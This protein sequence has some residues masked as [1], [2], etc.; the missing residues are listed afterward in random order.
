MKVLLVNPPFHEGYGTFSESAG[1][2][3]PLGLAYIAAM[4]EKAGIFVEIID[5]NALFMT[6][7]QLSM[8]IFE[9]H[10]DIV[11]SSVMTSTVPIVQKLARIAKQA[12]PNSIFIGGGVH[13]TACPIETLERVPEIDIGVIGEGEET[14]VELVKALQLKE[15]LSSVKG[16]AFRETGKIIVTQ[17]R[18]PIHNLDELPFPAYHLLPV[19]KYKPRIY[20]NIKHKKIVYMPVFS[21]RGCPNYCNFCDSHI[22]FGRTVRYRSVENFLKEIDFLVKT[23][24][25]NLINVHDDTFTLDKNR[26]IRICNEL[27]SRKHDLQWICQSRVNTIDETAFMKMKEAGCYLVLFGIESGNQKV[28]NFIRKGIVLEQA[29]KAIALTKKAKLK[30]ITSFIIGQPIDTIETINET[31]KFADEL[32]PTDVM[33]FLLSPYPGT[34]VY[35]Y[36]TEHGL[37]KGD[38]WGRS[39]SST[40][41]AV[42]PEG[43]TERQLTEKLEEAYRTFYLNPKRAWKLLFKINSISDIKGYMQGAYNLVLKPIFYK[44]NN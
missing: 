31:I 1:I 40:E 4:L 17:L 2:L 37:L 12:N 25:V 8:Q 26:V 44:N 35:K 16:I 13:I 34:E 22:L 10:P 24:G 28:L 43:M 36:A 30:S 27:I 23:Y 5:A 18:P 21:S 42:V 41:P 39:A 32:D 33:F 20:E 7:E 6:W 3:P 19:G 38:V 9:K 11:G 29:R 15:N 14:I